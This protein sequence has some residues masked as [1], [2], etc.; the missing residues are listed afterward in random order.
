MLTGAD[1][2]LIAVIVVL[3][4]LVVGLSLLSTDGKETVW[5][6]DGLNILAYA[7]TP[8]LEE[9]LPA[10]IDAFTAETGIGVNVILTTD[11]NQ[12]YLRA[13]VEKTP[14]DGIMVPF[15]MREKYRQRGQIIELHTLLDEVPATTF[16]AQMRWLWSSVD[17]R[18]ICGFLIGNTADPTFACVRHQTKRA[19]E[20]AE[21]IRYLV[22]HTSVRESRLV[23]PNHFARKLLL[24]R[25]F[26]PLHDR[27]LHPS[28]RMTPEGFS[29]IVDGAC[30]AGTIE[31]VRVVSWEWNVQPRV[32][33]VTEVQYDSQ[34]LMQ[35][36]I[37]YEC[38]RD[39]LRIQMNMPLIEVRNA[40]LPAVFIP[41]ESYDGWSYGRSRAQ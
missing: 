19:R 22:V 11:M 36:T 35:Y 38:I 21:L 30:P 28:R 9:E 24:E 39:G 29:R 23:Q 10:A 26:A 5:E 1:K 17:G 12:A 13:T 31:N 14:I 33:P 34:Q 8:F 6:P 15:D 20:V 16:Q 37:A 2:M 4:G 32:D 40:P 41:F 27:L 3:A 7:S 25:D 18:P